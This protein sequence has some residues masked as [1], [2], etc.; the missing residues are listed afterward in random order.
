MISNL[1]FSKFDYNLYYQ[2]LVGKKT[3]EKKNSNKNTEK[4]T[5]EKK[6]QSICKK[7]LSTYNK[8]NMASI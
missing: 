4:K 1:C 3:G 2:I 6:P 7:Y 5:Q 8:S